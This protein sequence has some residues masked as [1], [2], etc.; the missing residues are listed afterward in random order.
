MNLYAL[1]YLSCDFL[2]TLADGN[3]EIKMEFLDLC[4]NQNVNDDLFVK[5]K[6]SY[7]LDNLHY[8]N[9]VK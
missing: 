8:L 2:N 1:P 3:G 5:F 4:G 9:L 6:N 7:T